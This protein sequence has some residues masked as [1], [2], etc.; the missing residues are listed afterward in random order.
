MKQSPIMIVALVLF[1]GCSGDEKKQEIESKKSLSCKILKNSQVRCTF[2][3]SPLDTTR[4]VEFHWISPAQESDNRHRIIHYL[5]VTAPFMMN[6]IPKGAHLVSGEWR[7]RLMARQLLLS[8]G[9][10]VKI[11]ST[12]DCFAIAIPPFI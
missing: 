2:S 12:E 5:I 11:N 7:Q 4:G 10:E 6:A 1:L 9:C 3:T 8:L